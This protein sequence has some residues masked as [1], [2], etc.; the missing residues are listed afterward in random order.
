MCVAPDEARQPGAGAGGAAPHMLAGRGEGELRSCSGTAVTWPG[1][2]G[3][4]GHGLGSVRMRLDARPASG[5]AST[6]SSVR[7]GSAIAGLSGPP[8]FP[9]P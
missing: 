7:L 2:C 9:S 5:A 8:R 6:V 1:G 3:A 4:T